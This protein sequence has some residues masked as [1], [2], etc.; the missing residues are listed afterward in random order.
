MANQGCEPSGLVFAPGGWVRGFEADHGFS[1]PCHISYRGLK[2]PRVSAVFG[3]SGL[4]RETDLPQ[5]GRVRPLAR[6]IAAVRRLIDGTGDSVLVHLTKI[7][8][9][10]GSDATR[11]R[12]RP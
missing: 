9:S 2:L 5:V 4:R 11:V 1:R 3:R 6:D 7:R 8:V 12:G 10:Y